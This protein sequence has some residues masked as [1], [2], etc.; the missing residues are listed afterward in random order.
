MDQLNL[1]VNTFV[2]LLPVTRFKRIT[3]YTVRVEHDDLP[4]FTKFIKRH[5]SP[6]F[7]EDMDLIRS[8]MRNLGE[9][10]GASTDYFRQE[11]HAHAIPPSIGL[12]KKGCGLRLYCLRVNHRVV[13]LF[14]GG[15]KTSQ[16]AQDCPIVAPHFEL[17]N[18]LALAIWR[19]LDEGQLQTN[20][21]DDLVLV[22][23]LKIA[24]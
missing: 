1:K 3:Y 14:D 10:I 24:L 8:W 23:N 12:T 17:A 11:N 13:I 6:E 9:K 7:K 2:I 16:R 18:R 4:L 15:E 20:E 5:A 19:V 21:Y 22:P